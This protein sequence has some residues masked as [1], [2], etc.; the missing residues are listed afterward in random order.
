MDTGVM[1]G[2]AP[3]APTRTRPATPAQLD[4]LAAEL[5]HWQSG[6]LVDDRAATAILA[7]YHPSRRF[8]LSRL[9]LTLGAAFVGVGIIWRVASNLDQLPPL[10][11]FVVVA[12]FWLAFLVLGE[13]L[14]G[15][16]EHGGGVPS[17]VVG[18]VRILGA[19]TFGA[20]V[21]QAAQSLQVPAYEPQLLAWWGLGALV[22]AY[23]V[24]G[25]GPLVVGLLTTASWLVWQTTWESPDALTVLLVLFAAAAVA[26]SVAAL[27]ATRLGS[28]FAGFSASWREVGALLSLGAL[29]VAA[30]PFVTA[31]D[32]TGSPMLVVVL[33]AAG[34]AVV[35]GAGLATDNARLEPAMALVIAVVGVLLVLWE[36]GS[37]FDIDDQVGA[38][39]W[40]HA[41][42]GVIAY[43]AAAA[44]FAVLGVLRDSRRLTFLATAA[45]VVFTTFQA[46]AVFAAIVQGA[47][48]F[49]L[50]GLVFVGTGWLADRARRQLARSLADDTDARSDE[51]GTVR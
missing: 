35:A 28:S 14:A 9:L 3:T 23:A 32:F 15:R 10:V 17:P 37:D 34:L 47:W 48:L 12:A 51:E 50:L 30:L 19:L 31:D 24:R 43:V 13:L 27:H 16:R 4:W 7:G 2:P 46:F 49:V 6:G 44:W 41:A 1:T 18:C 21:F 42:L 5:P 26:A 11:R 20:V 8:D 29:F 38:A 33:V 22:H 40:A 45:L 39:G 25:N 36:V